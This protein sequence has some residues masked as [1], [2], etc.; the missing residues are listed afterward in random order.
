MAKKVTAIVKLQI[1]AGKATPQP[2]IGPAL[3]QAGVNI[4]EFC[5]AFNART[6]SQEGSTIPTVITVYSDRTFTFVTRTPPVSELLKKAAGIEKGAKMPGREKVARVS[7][8]QIEKI[9]ALKLPD[10]YAKD[11]QGA[12]KTIIGSAKSMGIEVVQ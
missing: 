8:E 4:M 3:G 5:K 11:M 12:I 6:A 1:P 7:M 9:A 10:L 2:P